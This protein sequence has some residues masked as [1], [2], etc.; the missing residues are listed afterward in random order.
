[1][2]AT[3]SFALKHNRYNPG[4]TFDHF[5]GRAPS[6]GVAG[7]G[8]PPDW[9]PAACPAA[10][11]LLARLLRLSRVTDGSRDIALIMLPML[12]MLS[13][14][15]TACR[16]STPE[17]ESASSCSLVACRLA[18]GELAPPRG[19]PSRRADSGL[20]PLLGTVALRTTGDPRADV[21]GVDTSA[22][23]E[24]TDVRLSSTR[25]DW[26]A[27]GV[28]RIPCFCIACNAQE[29]PWEKATH[30]SGAGA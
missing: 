5:A 10:M 16:A 20:A 11:A 22:D 27:I 30:G 26:G 25:G 8:T 1:M 4:V 21:D 13:S 18:P 19:Q 7:Y 28:M 15:R 6:A 17:R 24:A 12:L 9:G 3:D 23:C 14:L 29:Q 2:T